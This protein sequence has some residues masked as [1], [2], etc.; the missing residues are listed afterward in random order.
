MGREALNALAG[1]QYALFTRGQAELLGLTGKQIEGGVRA[2]AVAPPVPGRVPHGR[3]TGHRPSVLLAAVLANG[4][5]TVV[6]HR[7]AAWLWVW[8][9]T[10][11][12][13]SAVHATVRYP[14]W[15]G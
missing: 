7:A 12:W 5:G 6:S 10:C 3:R 9:T 1:R 4:A 13:R 2:L 8:S 14:G 15:L 11:A